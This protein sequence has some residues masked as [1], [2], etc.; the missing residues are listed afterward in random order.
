M[1]LATGTAEQGVTAS[2]DELQLLS[3]CWGASQMHVQEA[4]LAA[5]PLDPVLVAVLDT[6]VDVENPRLRDR[7]V[8]NEVFGDNS[9][10]L[11]VYG[12]GTH[13]AGTIIAIA[14]NSR[15]LNIK[16]AD[17]RGFCDGQDVAQAIRRAA[18]RGA[19]I[20]N[21]SLQVE[22][23]PELEAA[24]TYAWEK[25]AVLVAAAGMPPPTSSTTQGLVG[26]LGP[27]E[28]PCRPTMSAEVYPAAYAYC[29]AVTGTNECNDLAPVSNRAVWVDLAAPGYNTLSDMPG[30][31]RGYLTGTSTA[32][33]HVAGL[34]AL[35]YGLAVDGNGNGRVNDEVRHAMEITA[36]PLAIE[37]TGNGAVNALAAVTYLSS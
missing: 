3:E 31:E 13:V 2:Y 15:I 26:E 33:A 16:V 17:D 21:I 29:I 10:Y 22:P 37:G 34:A 14:P 7:V 30:G 19:A 28:G 8:G 12:H 6:G 20:I 24:I 18:S 5:G 36:E 35:L 9:E 4:W 11:D 25:G 1:T 27:T 23:S 32:S